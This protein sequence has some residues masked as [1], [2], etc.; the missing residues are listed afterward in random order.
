MPTKMPD[1][2]RARPAT[3]HE[4]KKE[5]MNR[6][7]SLMAVGVILG[8]CAQLSVATNPVKVARVREECRQQVQRL[9]ETGI[10]QV[11]IIPH[12]P[13]P[14]DRMELVRTFAQ[15]VMR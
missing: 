2:G 13:D 15:E 14:R 9:A 10:D 5:G 4:G 11:A 7:A 1:P 8:G 3:R 12:T 6:L